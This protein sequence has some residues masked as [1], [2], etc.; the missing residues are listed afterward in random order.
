MEETAPPAYTSLPPTQVPLPPPPPPTQ[1]PPPPT[2]TVLTRFTIGQS[3]TDGPLVSI[4][5][6]KAH[7]ALLHAFA[8]LKNSVDAVEVPIV[9]N[10][11]QDKEK[12]WTWFVGCA[13][14][15]CVDLKCSSKVLSHTFV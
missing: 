1:V 4:P 5:E 15:R 12:R 13:V 7:L 8:E 11:P 9:S 10:V 3:R 14:E 6:I 2:Y